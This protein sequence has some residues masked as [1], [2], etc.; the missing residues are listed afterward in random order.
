MNINEH[1]STDRVIEIQVYL[2]LKKLIIIYIIQHIR[3]F[4]VIIIL[5]KYILGQSSTRRVGIASNIRKH[6]IFRKIKE[7]ISN[8][9]SFIF[10]NH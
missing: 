9:L 7:C 6:E 10:Q 1:G 5:C 4:I 3:K 8:R 2:Y